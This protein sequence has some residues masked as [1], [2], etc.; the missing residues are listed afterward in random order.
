MTD[1]DGTEA[2]AQMSE[3]TDTAARKHHPDCPALYYTDM[4][5]RC[6]CVFLAALDRSRRVVPPDST[7]PTDEKKS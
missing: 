3:H 2:L 4:P 6:R 5:Y 7:A 1:H